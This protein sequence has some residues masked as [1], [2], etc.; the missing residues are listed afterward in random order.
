MKYRVLLE[1]AVDMLVL[2]VLYVVVAY[3]TIASTP[4]QAAEKP[5]KWCKVAKGMELVVRCKA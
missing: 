1:L 3:I 5:W 2:V 4:A